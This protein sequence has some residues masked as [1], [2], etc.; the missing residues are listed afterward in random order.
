MHS[1]NSL[2]SLVSI[3]KSPVTNYSCTITRAQK[4]TKNRLKFR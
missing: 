2:M 3:G 1:T 4:H